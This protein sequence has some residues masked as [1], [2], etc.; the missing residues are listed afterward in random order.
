VKLICSTEK[1]NAF[2][3]SEMHRKITPNETTEIKLN[4][5]EGMKCVP[6]F[7]PRYFCF[8]LLD[9]VNFSLATVLRCNLNKEE[10]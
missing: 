1:F 5:F 3:N 10:F 6:A 9:L 4:V 8:Q 2:I 7:Y